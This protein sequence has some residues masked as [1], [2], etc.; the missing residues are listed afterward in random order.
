P[1]EIGKP[2]KVPDCRS[3]STHPRG[4]GQTPCGNEGRQLCLTEKAGG[5]KKKGPGQTLSI[6]RGAV[7]FRVY[8]SSS[9]LP[10]VGFCCPKEG[11]S[12]AGIEPPPSRLSSPGAGAISEITAGPASPPSCSS[13]KLSSNVRSRVREAN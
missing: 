11:P 4:L 8:N 9:W 10:S 12:V 3:L 2:F 6:D 7:S 1:R 13:G 5:L